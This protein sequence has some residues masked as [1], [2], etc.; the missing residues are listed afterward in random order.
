MAEP[1]PGLDTI[2]AIDSV[3]HIIQVA[4]TP[5]FLLSGIGN[6]LSVFN[7]RLARVSDHTE[8]AAELLDAEPDVDRQVELLIHLKRLRR[9]QVVLDA[10]VLF[11]GLGGAATCGA[12]FVLFLG[13]SRGSGVGAWLF[14]LFG[15]A[16]GCTVVALMAFLIDSLMAWHG[17]RKEGPLP[18]P[19][20]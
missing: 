2:G 18:R 15:V 5:V 6:L 19:K 16:L 13:S 8:H 7:T 11:G 4:L 20:G 12:A 10:A 14:G 9:R 1:I 17:L 3:A